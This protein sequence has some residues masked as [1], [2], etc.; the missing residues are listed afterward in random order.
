MKCE[1]ALSAETWHLL[2]VVYWN[3]E[4]LVR[5]QSAVRNDRLNHGLGR[6]H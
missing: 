5:V 2:L 6:L 3:S 4:L 1:S